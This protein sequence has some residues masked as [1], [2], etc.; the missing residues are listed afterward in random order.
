MSLFK[1]ASVV[2]LLTLLSR[3]SGLVRD[4]LIAATFG[5][6]AM[7]DAF[8]VAFRI[9]NLLRRLFAEG[10]FSQAFVPVLAA[11]RAQEGDEATKDLIDRVAT[12]LAWALT[13]TCIVGVLAAPLLV[14]AMASGLA[15]DPYT[16]DVTVALTRWMFPY[17]GFMS[18]VALAAGVLNTWKRFAVPAATPVLLNVGLILAAA[19]GAPWFESMGIEP[20]MALAG[21]VL[22]GGTLQLA[23]QLAALKRLGLLPRVALRWSKVRAA[24]QHPGTQRIL[25]LMLPAL[26]GVSVAQISLLINTQ[27]ASHLATGSVSWLTFADRLMEFPTA[28]LGVALGVV[29]LPQLAAASAAADP[30]RYSQMLDWGLRLVLVLAVPSAVA[31]LTIAVPLVSVLFHYGAFTAFDVRQT[32]LALMGYGVGLVGLIAIK[33]LAPAF[34]AKQDIKTPVRIAIVVLVLT[35]V[36]N[37]LLVPT[38]AHAGLALAIGLGALINAGWLLIGLLRRG[39]YQPQPG[40]LVLALQVLAASALLALFLLWGSSQFDWLHEDVVVWQRLLAMLGLM[41]GAALVYFGTLLLAGA[42]LKRL[43]RM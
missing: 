9:P 14:W 8:N 31:L 4:L 13:L 35:Q 40:W 32:A 23:V 41:V 2:S 1:S 27:I 33:I 29:L 22:L 26:L 25:T 37:L 39:S 38:M 3:I 17:I 24:W 10:A 11:T 18:L 21:G 16:F 36:F 30:A 15:R 20:I 42:K 28:L 12:V 6:S 43:V 7:T 5:V 19:W 34:Y